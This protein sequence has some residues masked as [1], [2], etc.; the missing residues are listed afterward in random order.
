MRT[1]VKGPID[2]ARA[3]RARRGPQRPDPGRGGRRRPPTFRLGRDR[4]VV[5]NHATPRQRDCTRGR[6]CRSHAP[7]AVGA[8]IVVRIKVA[9]A[10]TIG[11][12]GHRILPRQEIFPVQKQKRDGVIAKLLQTPQLSNPLVLLTGNGTGSVPIAASSRPRLLCAH[13]ER[14]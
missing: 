3:V 14:G 10:T 2:G 5:E 8:E 7:T 9:G 4:T 6:V 13:D 1:K 11:T 12:T